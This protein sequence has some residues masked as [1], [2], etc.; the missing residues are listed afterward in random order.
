MGKLLLGI[1]I[2]RRKLLGAAP[3]K[4]NN[5]RNQLPHSN[6]KFE[7]GVLK[8]GLFGGKKYFQH[9]NAKSNIPKIVIDKIAEFGRKLLPQPLYSPDLTPS[10]QHLFCWLNN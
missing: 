7:S 3:G 9:D 1:F 4:H 10:D 6:R 8:Q 5:K 2:R